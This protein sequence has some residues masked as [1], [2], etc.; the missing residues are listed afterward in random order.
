MQNPIFT[1][2]K[3]LEWRQRVENNGVQIKHINVLAEIIRNKNFMEL[4][5]I[6]VSLALKAR[7]L[8]VL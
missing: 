7:K 4:Y 6:V 8:P 1:N 3:Y 2:S 5:W